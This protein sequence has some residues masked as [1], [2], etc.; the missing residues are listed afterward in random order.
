MN[1]SHYESYNTIIRLTVRH[2]WDTLKGIFKVGLLGHE[3]NEIY[4]QYVRL[5][6]QRH[7]MN[8]SSMYI[9]SS[10][11][12]MHIIGAI[13]YLDLNYRQS[14]QSCYD[15]YTVR[16][17]R[18]NTQIAEVINMFNINNLNTSCNNVNPTLN[19]SQSNSCDISITTDNDFKIS[20]KSSH[21]VRLEN[22]VLQSNIIKM[23]YTIQQHRLNSLLFIDNQKYKTLKYYELYGEYTKIYEDLMHNYSLSLNNTLLFYNDIFLQ[24]ERNNTL[25]EYLNE[26]NNLKSEYQETI[27]TLSQENRVYLATVEYRYN[28]EIRI[29]K[30]SEKHNQKITELEYYYNMKS[31]E[32]VITLL[33]NEIST[34]WYDRV[35]TRPDLILK[36]GVLTICSIIAILLMIEMSHYFYDNYLNVYGNS[37][38]TISKNKIAIRRKK[39][40]NSATVKALLSKTSIFTSFSAVEIDNEI[41]DC[42][43]VVQLNVITLISPQDAFLQ[44]LTVK[45]I[46]KASRKNRA[47]QKHENDCYFIASDQVILDVQRI[48]HKYRVI[49]ALTSMQTIL[50]V[51]NALVLGHRGIGKSLLIELIAV[52]SGLNYYILNGRDLLALNNPQ[53]SAKYLQKIVKDIKLS[54]SSNNTS[55]LIFIDDCDSFIRSRQH[56]NASSVHDC[57]YT[58]LDFMRSDMSPNIGFILVSS[59]DS[60]ACVDSAILDR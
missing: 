53:I 37:I 23:N 52:S 50:P 24:L 56:Y 49:A 26:V 18:L 60:L 59:L 20:W 3:V 21:D 9:D 46:E 36:Y 43:N 45:N 29:Q 4:P 35:Y 32:T 12:L 30:L 57:F 11:M 1:V 58:L 39:I 16:N 34:I 51:P 17:N 48:I 13:Q 55:S 40:M 7:G 41:T 38:S 31:I 15:D 19:P 6:D 44:L 8:E 33:F 14:I 5:I 22:E 10:N 54:S 28:E 27:D 42:I 2:Y 25:N 47:I